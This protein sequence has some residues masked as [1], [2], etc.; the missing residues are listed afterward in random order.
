VTGA[1]EPDA[2][3][4]LIKFLASAEAAPV[5]KKAGLDPIVAGAK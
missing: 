5:I 3:R 1:K 4:A 2:G